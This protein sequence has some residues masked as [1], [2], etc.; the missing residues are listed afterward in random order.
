R[1]ADPARFNGTVVVE[2]LN[3][4][5]GGDAAPE[6]I[7]SHNELIRDGFAWVGVSA[8]AAGGA[9]GQAIRDDAAQILGGLRP[10]AVLAEGESQSAARLTTYIDAIQPLAHEYDGF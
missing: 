1:P 3:V 10:R 2:W 9:A 5:A 4:S 7:F 8:Q 6:W